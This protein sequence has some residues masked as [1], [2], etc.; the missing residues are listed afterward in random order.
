MRTFLFS[1][2][3]SHKFWNIELKGAAFTVT[4]GRVGAAGTAQTKTFPDEARARKEHDKLV[5]E[6]LKKGY[7]ETTP[8]AGKPAAPAP[9]SLRESLEAA[10]VEEPDDL[11]HHMAYADYL[12]EQGDPLGDFVRVQLALED[13]TK[14][15]AERKKF[16]QQ[17]KALLGKHAKTWLGELATY[18]DYEET[19]DLLQRG[20]SL[21][22]RGWLDRLS[23]GRLT[24][25]YA[26]TLARAPQTHLL[27]ALEIASVEWGGSEAALMPDEVRAVGEHATALDLLPASPHL[28]NVHQ[29]HIGRL[30]DQDDYQRWE[31]SSSG[32]G[33]AVTKLVA[34]MPGLQEL[35]VWS[36]AVDLD[37]LFALPLRELRVLQ[38]YHMN[39]RHPLEKLAKNATLGK[40][41]HLQ[42]HP[43]YHEE[44]SEGDDFNP[45][46]AYITR[47][48]LRAVVGSPH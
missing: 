6:K 42:F 31:G 44:Y 4:F 27:R 41:T 24:V 48:G 15:P 21:F 12:T 19:V 20:A 28:G 39:Q 29:L 22:R 47:K 11:A 36:R 1:D 8:G 23:L 45:E 33:P 25:E 10:L 35:R 18:R 38:V 40:L 37:K 16:Q 9:A 34:R 5:A 3:K 43:H 7:V 14:K 13:E 2:E 26:R 46:D 32:T 30:S 17:E